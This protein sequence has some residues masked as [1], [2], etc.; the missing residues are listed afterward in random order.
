MKVLFLDIDGVVNSA[1]SFKRKA[2]YQ[3]WN[4]I[5]PELAQRVRDI[6]A[7]THCHVVLS[8]SWRGSV[9]NEDIIAR[10]VTPLLDRTPRMH[11]PVGT[12][13]E[14]CERGREIKAWME[15]HPTMEFQY[16]ILDDDSDM[17]P[18]QKPNF[19]H[20]SWETGLTQEITQ[21]VINHLT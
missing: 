1:E 20:T 7:A 11:R 12:G 21:Q 19:F 9:E 6:V 16:A 14:Y 2:G 13:M 10:H 3:K 4:Q 8:S 15:A 5:D 18:E 17:L